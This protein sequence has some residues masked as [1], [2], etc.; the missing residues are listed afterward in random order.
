VSHA[1]VRQALHP[2]HEIPQLSRRDRVNDHADPGAAEA[3]TTVSD[4]A[5]QAESARGSQS[6]FIGLGAPFAARYAPISKRLPHHN[7][8]GRANDGTSPRRRRCCYGRILELAGFKS[9]AISGVSTIKAYCSRSLT[10]TVPA[11]FL[12]QTAVWSSVY[13]REYLEKLP[14]SPRPR[15]LASGSVFWWWFPQRIDE[16]I[17][18][19]LFSALRLGWTLGDSRLSGASITDCVDN[20]PPSRRLS[21]IFID[22][23]A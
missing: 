10:A 14:R 8:S 22:R 11:L 21:Y 9:T 12:K 15:S 4:S 1:D 17:R 3:Q 16:R 5:A 23:T 2:D 6:F 7:A 18:A 13:G 19:N 20:V